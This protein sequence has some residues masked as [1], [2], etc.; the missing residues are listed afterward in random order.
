[1]SKKITA[2]KVECYAITMGD[3][4]VGEFK[5][6]SRWLDFIELVNDNGE[7]IIAY[8]PKEG[9]LDM[10]DSLFGRDT[11]SEFT[12]LMASPEIINIGESLEDDGD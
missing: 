7:T 12:M 9:I 6:K 2:K 8:S 11:E 10:L 5:A 4:Y 3:Y 1:M